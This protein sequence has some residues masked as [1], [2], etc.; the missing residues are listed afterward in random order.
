MAWIEGTVIKSVNQFPNALC[1]RTCKRILP[2]SLEMAN[3][4]PRTLEQLER[5]SCREA[6]FYTPG[7]AGSCYGTMIVAGLEAHANNLIAINDYYFTFE[8]RAF[9]E[10]VFGRQRGPIQSQYNYFHNH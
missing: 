7:S 6:R 4:P 8:S 1:V 3:R 2:L 10:E 5:M 9:P